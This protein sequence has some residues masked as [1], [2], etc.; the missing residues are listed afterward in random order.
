KNKL[1]IIYAEGGISSGDDEEEIQSAALSSTIR[2][3]REDSTIKAIVL[4]VNSPGGSGLASEVIWREVKLAAE[5][6]P[7]VV[8][9]GNVAASGGYYIALAGDHVIA[10]ESTVTGSIGVI[11]QTFNF[12]RGMGM[13]GVEG[14]ALT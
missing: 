2:K 3:A 9:M 10:Q 4:R 7:L 6:K 1:A 13:I 11:F 5:A 8:S 14:R 12:S